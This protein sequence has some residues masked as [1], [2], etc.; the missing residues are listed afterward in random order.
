M[1]GAF[2][3][4]RNLSSD[5]VVQLSKIGF[6]KPVLSHKVLDLLVNESLHITIFVPVLLFE[7]G[8]EHTLQLLSL[9][10]LLET[11]SA[12]LRHPGQV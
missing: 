3:S 12:G 2:L 11:S 1:L 7:F 4:S 10:D 9:L 8:N 5:L 6:G